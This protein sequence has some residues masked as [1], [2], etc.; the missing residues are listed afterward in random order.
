[1]PHQFHKAL[2]EAREA[3]PYPHRKDFARAADM[4]EGG[5]RKIESGDRVPDAETLESIIK[6]AR[7]PPVQAQEL[8]SLRNAALADRVGV[9]LVETPAVDINTIA[10]RILTEVT[11][12][13]RKTNPGVRLTPH[14]RRILMN[15]ITIILRAALEK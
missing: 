2:R 9:D 5:L 14:H 10:E 3:S 1:M 15:R 4:S 11:V 8:R 13:L 12:S 7:I 6:C